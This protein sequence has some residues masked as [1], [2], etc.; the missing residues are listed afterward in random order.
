MKTILVILINIKKGEGNREENISKETEIKTEKG[1]RIRTGTR[2]LDKGKE[3]LNI[4][5]NT[6]GPKDKAK[7]GI[8]K[9]IMTF[10][11]PINK[12]QTSTI[13]S[14]IVL[15]RKDLKNTRNTRGSK[16]IKTTKKNPNNGETKD[17]NTRTIKEE[18][19]RE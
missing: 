14:S 2:D 5:R 11:D 6:I 18:I 12:D 8:T 17:N 3:D 9:I 19:N 16:D 1:I 13:D 7:E 10:K 4:K 15:L